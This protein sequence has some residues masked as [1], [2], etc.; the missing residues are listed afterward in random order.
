MMGDCLHMN[1]DEYPL[2][3]TAVVNSIDRSTED[4]APNLCLPFD[5]IGVR[6]P[7]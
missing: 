1:P 2:P 7:G 5:G 4:R 3:F 6:H